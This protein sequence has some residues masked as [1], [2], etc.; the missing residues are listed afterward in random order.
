MSRDTF[1]ALFLSILIILV[2]LLTAC[3]TSHS[4]SFHGSKDSVDYFRT[5]NI[6]WQ[7]RR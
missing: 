6:E 3:K 1:I 5:G 7:W 2:L 4:E